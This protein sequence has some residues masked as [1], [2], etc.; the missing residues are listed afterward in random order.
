MNNFHKDDLGC[1][2]MTLSVSFI[3]LLGGQQEVYLN[4]IDSVRHMPH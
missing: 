3:S 4:K 1:I 2:H